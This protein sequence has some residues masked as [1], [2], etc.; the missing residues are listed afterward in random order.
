MGLEG[1]GAAW[2]FLPTLARCYR[3]LGFTPRPVSCRPFPGSIPE[4]R[5]CARDLS[6]LFWRIGLLGMDSGSP[7]TVLGGT[8]SLSWAESCFFFIWGEV[9]VVG[10]GVSCKPLT[11]FFHRDSQLPVL[12]DNF[13][14]FWSKADSSWRKWD[15]KTLPNSSTFNF[16]FISSPPLKRMPSPFT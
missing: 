12:H 1:P 2:T 4:D 3:P 15:F 7:V 6:P 8:E 14:K 5:Y 9:V 13:N 11:F 10:E 16:E